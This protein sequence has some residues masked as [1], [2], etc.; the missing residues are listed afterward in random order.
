M[1]DE[2]ALRR[3][4]FTEG[5]RVVLG[6]GQEWSLPEHVFCTFPDY[7]EDGRIV[8][9]YRVFYGEDADADLDAWFGS[10]EVDPDERENAKMRLASSLLLRNY[11]L[12]LPALRTLLRKSGADSASVEMWTGLTRAVLGLSPKASAGGSE[13]PSSPTESPADS[14]S[15]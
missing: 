3:D 1:L 12:D 13:Q 10:A 11:D 4:G 8:A 14:P 15:P 6:D 9:G 5:I 7:D 2:K